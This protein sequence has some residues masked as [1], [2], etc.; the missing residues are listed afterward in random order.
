MTREQLERER[1]Y[2]AAMSIAKS[3]LRARLITEREYRK[4]D[5]M[6]RRKYRPIIGGLQLNNP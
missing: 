6:Y 5:T 1:D 4:I 3:L 2:G